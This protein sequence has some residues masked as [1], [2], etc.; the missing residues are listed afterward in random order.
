MTIGSFSVFPKTDEKSLKKYIITLKIIDDTWIQIRD[1]NDEIIFSQLMS[2]NY[3]Y[4]YDMFDNYSITSGNAGNIML[5]I[6]TKV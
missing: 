5:L 1:I 6:N 3:E 2:N 4:S